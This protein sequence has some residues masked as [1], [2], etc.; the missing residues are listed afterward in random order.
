MTSHKSQGATIAA[1]I[2]IDIK[3]TFEPGFTYVIKK[4]GN[5]IINDFTPC[6]FIED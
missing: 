3:K 2:I 1:K 6:N 5:L 4:I